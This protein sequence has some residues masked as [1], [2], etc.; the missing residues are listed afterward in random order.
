[1]TTLTLPFPS[2]DVEDAK[3]IRNSAWLDCSLIPSWVDCTTVDLDCFYTLPEV[4]RECRDSLYAIMTDDYADL[5]R[6]QFV[7]PGAGAGAFYNLMPEGR[8]IGVDVFPLRHEF[9]QQDYLTWAPPHSPNPYAVLG[10]PPFGYRAWLALAFL[11][12]SAT[13]ADYIGFV[14]PMAFQSDGKGSPKHRVKGAELVLSER[15]P[16]NAFVDARGQSVKLNALWQ[17]WRRGVNNV[18]PAQTCADWVDLFTVDTRKERLCGHRRLHEATWFIQRTFFGEPPT[19]V[20][21]FADVRYGCGYGI[22]IKKE[23]EAITRVLRDTDWRQYSNL[24]LHNCRHI[25]MY[26]IRQAV[27]DAGF[28]DV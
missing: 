6:Y 23:V 8:R 22:V 12:H 1:M 2:F 9:I 3:S 11:N 4:A 20:T 26:H 18:P 28:T 27:I 15:M 25:S 19:L 14:V 7:D 21:D 17:I 13:F 5:D 16:D 24:A 10:N